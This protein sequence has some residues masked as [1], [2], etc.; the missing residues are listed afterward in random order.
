VKLEPG[1]KGFKITSIDLKTEGDVPG[2][3]EA[4]F[5]EQAEL[6]KKTCPVSVA[7]AG[8]KINLDAKL[9]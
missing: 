9:L 2:I 4:K 1:D 8:T 5:K 6:T 3:N 7:L